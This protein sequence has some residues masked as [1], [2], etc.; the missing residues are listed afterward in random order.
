MWNE[1]SKKVRYGKDDVPDKY[2]F[3]KKMHAIWDLVEDGKGLDEADFK[4]TEADKKFYDSYKSEFDREKKARGAAY[5][6]P[7]YIV[8]IDPE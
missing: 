2:G 5:H 6:F 4:A 3:T 7:R 1:V 8:D